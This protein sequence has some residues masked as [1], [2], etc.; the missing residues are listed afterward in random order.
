MLTSEINILNETE[1]L[2]SVEIDPEVEYIDIHG[3]DMN[4]K[5]SH[6]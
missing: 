6:L 2:L 3:D 5:V 4:S 1:F